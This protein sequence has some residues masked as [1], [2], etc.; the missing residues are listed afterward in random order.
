MTTEGHGDETAEQENALRQSPE[1]VVWEE[2]LTTV[3]RCF[4]DL[5]E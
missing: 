2:R 3:R 1:A 4:V 5:P